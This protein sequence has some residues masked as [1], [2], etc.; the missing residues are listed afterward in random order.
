M[1]FECISCEKLG[2]SCNGPHFLSVSVPEIMEWC[3]QRKA[4]LRWSN[5]KISEEANTPK[6]T[7]DRLF[8][9]DI[10]DC[11]V[12]TLRPII[13]AL[14]GGSFIDDVCPC[15]EPDEK[16]EETIR[17]LEQDN[18]RLKRYLQN[19][20][21]KC[22]ANIEEMKADHHAETDFLKQQLEHEQA[23]SES[24]KKAFYIVAICLGFT[25]SIII[26]ALIID[27]VN[28]DIGFFW[29]DKMASIMSGEKTNAIDQVTK[30]FL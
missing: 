27:R 17:R 21:E 19:T 5:A 12:E 30:M 15:L 6:G 23:T 3:I 7:V 9:G 18:A 13:Q 14:I 20:E 25:L 11:K 26:I 4:F 16:A 28:P 10:V 2:S 24:R 8:S 1:F 29:I 22:K